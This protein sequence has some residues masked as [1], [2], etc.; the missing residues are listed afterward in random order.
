MIGL[1]H[2][3]IVIHHKAPL[4]FWRDLSCR[5]FYLFLCFP[6]LKSDQRKRHQQHVE[7][8]GHYRCGCVR[9]GSDEDNTVKICKICALNLL[10][11]RKKI[12]R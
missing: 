6:G 10:K 5:E 7:S 12:Y 2:T 4:A 9:T 3:G 11:G 1:G 8:T